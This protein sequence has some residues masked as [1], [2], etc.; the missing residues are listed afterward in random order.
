MASRYM[1]E[2]HNCAVF[3][4]VVPGYVLSPFD[5]KVFGLYNQATEL[6]FVAWKLL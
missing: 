1:N 6:H 5:V 3:T 4:F 2:Y